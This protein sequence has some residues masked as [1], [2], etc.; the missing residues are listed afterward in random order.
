MLGQAGGFRLGPEYGCIF[1][2][3][4]GDL[5]PGDIINESGR[6]VASIVVSNEQG[7]VTLRNMAAYD[8]NKNPIGTVWTNKADAPISHDTVVYRKAGNGFPWLLAGLGV[9][10]AGAAAYYFFMKKPASA[11]ALGHVGPSSRAQAFIGKKIRKLIRDEGFE[12]RQA[13]AVAYSMA[14]KR[15]FKVPAV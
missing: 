7:L 15:G 6:R 13:A 11:A 5:Q 3:K 10:A 8:P 2:D 14:R 4:M 9:V 12:P 1:V